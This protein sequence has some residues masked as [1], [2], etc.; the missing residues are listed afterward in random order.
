MIPIF[1]DPKRF[2]AALGSTKLKM[3]KLGS[4]LNFTHVSSKKVRA[5][6]PAFATFAWNSF[7]MGNNYR[8]FRNHSTLPLTTQKVIKIE[9][10]IVKNSD[11]S[12]VA[13]ILKLEN[14]RTEDWWTGKPPVYGICP[15]VSVKG[16]IHSMPQLN[17]HNC[18][19]KV[20]LNC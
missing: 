19:K 2:V 7:S 12:S 4:R 9:S 17:T 20:S 6:Q 5:V 11:R 16:E 15:G 13:S 10:S 1:S 18:T 8:V 3:T 14:G